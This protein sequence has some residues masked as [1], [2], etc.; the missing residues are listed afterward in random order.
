MNIAVC[1]D[2]NFVMQC[3]VLLKSIQ[4]NNPTEEINFY[5]LTMG[6]SDKAK[7]QLQNVSQKN[8]QIH[9][10][11]ISQTMLENF[12]IR[13]VDHLT[14]ATYLRLF[15]PII[16]PQD[17]H[18]IIYLDCDMIV[19]DSLSSLWNIDISDFSTGMVVDM[20]YLD[21]T[22]TSRLLYKKD[23]GYFN[24]G[25]L[26][27]NLD[28]WKENDISKKTT[29][30]LVQNPD[31]CLVHDQDAINAVLHGTIKVIPA[32]YNV[33]QDFCRKDLYNLPID[34]QN[35]KDIK[36]AILNPCVIHYTGPSKP[37][38]K[39]CFNPYQKVWEYYQSQTQWKNV[40]K[41]RELKGLKYILRRIKM[42]FQ[43]IG[44]IKPYNDFEDLSLVVKCL[45][46]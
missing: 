5:I 17:I 11:E 12:P 46:E 31:R 23:D 33:Q 43:K 22:Q 29:E 39:E 3:G 41:T 21:E 28:Y 26:L 7:E 45:S 8:I 16:L 36:E 24:A 35:Q 15:L 25:T 13:S 6:L 37:W 19:C 18:K 10:L 2:E 30:F 38:K 4:V 14:L 32:R 27:V 34:E 40:K 1:I 42:F 9:F 44:I 20:F